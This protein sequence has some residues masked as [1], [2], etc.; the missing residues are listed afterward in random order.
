MDM[1]MD[2]AGIITESRNPSGAQD[3]PDKYPADLGS[4]LGAL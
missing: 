3:N 2:P 4:G 1:P